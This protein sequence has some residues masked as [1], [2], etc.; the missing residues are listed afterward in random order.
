MPSKSSLNQSATTIQKNWK[1]H[2]TRNRDE[3]VQDLK[4][5][6][7]GLRTDEHIKHLTKE[8]Q[9]AKTALEQER[10]LRALQMDAIKVLWKEVQLMDATKNDGEVG[11]TKPSGSF[12]SKISSRSSEHSIAKLME[13]LEAT[14][15]NGG[16]MTGSPSG[17]SGSSADPAVVRRL[18]DTCNSLQSQVEQLQTSLN[19]VMKF[20]T[21]MSESMHQ[22]RTRHSSST[23]TTQDTT[24]FQF[25]P[26][27]T[28]PQSLPPSMFT[29]AVDPN[30]LQSQSAAMY[31]SLDPETLQ[32]HHAQQEQQAQSMSKSCDS[33]VQTEISAILTPKA[34]E[35]NTNF[36]HLKAVDISI[37][38]S[39]DSEVVTS[40]R[41]PRS[42]SPRPS[43]LPGLNEPRVKKSG[44]VPGLAHLAGKA[45]LASPKA[46]DEVKAFART[47]VQGLLTEGMTSKK[48]EEDQGQGQGQQD[49]TDASL[50]LANEEESPVKPVQGQG[51]ADEVSVSSQL[52]TDSLEE[53]SPKK[54][55]A[56]KKE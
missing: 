36:L 22:S 19:G 9:S 54:V 25:Y 8:L 40:S 35:C 15:G 11:K 26:T 50:S 7:R 38:E 24:S 46:P 17:S 29:S 41:S 42:R 48:P 23:S 30:A 5:E 52:E 44:S 33:L 16:G 49:E 6:I 20:M 34:E 3:K 12:G 56:T 45:V 47:L 1:G 32:Q 2:Q 27:P 51:Q 31:T 43:T 13:T 28:G 21:S 39:T 55:I 4:Q 18:N 53:N 14:A 10:K 37:G